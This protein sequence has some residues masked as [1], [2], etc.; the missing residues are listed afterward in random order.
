MPA[1]EPTPLSQIPALPSVDH[2]P[3]MLDLPT[4]AA[5]LGISRATIYRLAAKDALPVPVVTV[6]NSRRIPAT[7]LL[8][9]LGLTPAPSTATAPDN[10]TGAPDTGRAAD[11]ADTA[12]NGRGPGSDQDARPGGL[13]E[14]GPASGDGK[15]P[16]R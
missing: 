4:A 2:L 1:I 9:L 12:P 15:T 16:T 3:A 10:G 5:L 13:P 8:A 6:G 7:P 14:P 11:P